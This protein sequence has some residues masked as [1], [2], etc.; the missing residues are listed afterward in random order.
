MAVA[1]YI[2]G[3]EAGT[4]RRLGLGRSTSNRDDL[5]EYAASAEEEAKAVS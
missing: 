5:R 3:K 4:T 2:H 1:H